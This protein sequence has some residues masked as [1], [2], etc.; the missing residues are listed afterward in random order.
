MILPVTTITISSS[1][2]TT[3]TSNTTMT[4]DRRILPTTCVS[5]PDMAGAS[6]LARSSTCTDLKLHTALLWVLM[7]DPF[8][9]CAYYLT[10]NRNTSPLAEMSAGVLEQTCKCLVTHRSA[11]LPVFKV[12]PSYSPQ[13]KRRCNQSVALLIKAKYKDSQAFCKYYTNTSRSISPLF[14]L[15]PDDVFAGCSRLEP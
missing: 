4:I 8:D 5:G 7:K 2:I 10:A 6:L 13:P 9:F 15:K 3:V 14:L 12:G 1:G 11:P